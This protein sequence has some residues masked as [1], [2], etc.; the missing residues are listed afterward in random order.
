M[1]KVAEYF[2]R[3]LE[4]EGVFFAEK[5]NKRSNLEF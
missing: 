2:T 3:R 1:Q 4:F 5:E